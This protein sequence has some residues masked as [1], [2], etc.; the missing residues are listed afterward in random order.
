MTSD[1]GK[2]QDFSLLNAL[3]TVVRY[4]RLIAANVTIVVV[5]AVVISLLLPKWYQ[6]TAVALPPENSL[7]PLTDFG[8]LQAVATTANLPWF[9][10]TSDLYGA[11]LE[12]RYVS[13]QIIERF[14]LLDVYQVESMDKAIKVLGKHRRVRVTDEDLIQ[15]AIEARD[16]ERA[17]SMANAFLEILDEFNQKT[18]MTEGRRTREFVEERLASTRRRLADAESALRWFQEENGAVELSGQTEALILAAAEI[19]SQ[20]R[21]VETRIMMMRSYATEDF[22]EIRVL[23]TQKEGLEEQLDNLLRG[24]EYGNSLVDK[25]GVK[26]YPS[27]AELPDL[28]MQYVRLLRDVELQTKIQAFLAQELERAKIKESRDTPTIQVLD[29]ASP[30]D[31]KNRPKRSLIVIIAFVAALFAS[32][33]LAFGLD[34]IGRWRE[35]EE[36]VRRLNRIARTL[37]EDWKRPK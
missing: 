11:V 20:I 4:R 32:V 19:E 31:R 10:T 33:A 23:R 5:A 27:L 37:A 1:H 22:P 15:V 13:E 8:A 7:D 16:P 24:S 25:A 3:E 12:S 26:P 30:P 35:D 9:A 18:R 14:R 36:N 6:S 21:A 29:R 17:A 28:G 2:P 34:G